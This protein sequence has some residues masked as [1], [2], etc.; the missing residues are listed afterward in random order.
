VKSSFMLVPEIE[1]ETTFAKKSVYNM[2]SSGHGPL[3]EILCKVGG[4]LGC[5]REDFDIWK[6]ARRRLKTPAAK[7]RR[8]P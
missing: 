4:K 1:Q 2:H 3:A 5:W 6:A 8:A 7:C